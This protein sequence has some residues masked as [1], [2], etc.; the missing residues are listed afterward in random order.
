M[1]LKAISIFLILVL[2]STIHVNG[3]E[4]ITPFSLKLYVY[5]DGSVL[6]ETEK[7]IR[8]QFEGVA[9]SHADCFSIFDNDA[10]GIFDRDH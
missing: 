6:V 2:S 1:R 3:Q 5:S 9:V 7:V 8:R 10:I 4:N